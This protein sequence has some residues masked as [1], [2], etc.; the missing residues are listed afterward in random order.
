MRVLVVDDESGKREQIVR[1][2]ATLP[3]VTAVDQAKSF[4]SAMERITADNYEYVVL[5]MR[6]TSFDVTAMDDGG[7]P[8]NFGGDE[9]LRKMKRRGINT[10]VI[11]LTQYSMF[12]SQGAVLSLEQLAAQFSDKYP[13][14]VGL[15]QFQH[16]N[17]N[18][19]E[20]L[21]SALQPGGGDHE[22]S[23]RR[24]R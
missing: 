21:R 20:R 4:Q 9:V 5:D 15:I 18:W 1:F 2:L 23:D 10:R 24:G 11:V 13:A 19:Q 14:F 12:H 6:L 16:S 7:R 17:T 8:R 22:G 3:S